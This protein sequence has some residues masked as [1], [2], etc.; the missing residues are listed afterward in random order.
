MRFLPSAPLQSLAF[1]GSGSLRGAVLMGAALALVGSAQAFQDRYVT[2]PGMPGSGLTGKQV[3]GVKLDLGFAVDLRSQI[4]L[5][6]PG[7]SG[8]LDGGLRGLDASLR[9]QFNRDLW[10]FALVEGTE[11]ELTLSQAAL[12]YQGLSGSS[13]LRLG[14]LPIDFGKQMQAR[15]YELPYPERP[16]VLRAYLGDQVLATGITYGDVFATGEHSTLR[17]SLGLF[18]QTERQSSPIGGRPLSLPGMEIL[19]GPRLDELAVNA[20]LTG[21]VDVGAEGIFQWGFSAHS[22]PD[23]SVAVVAS[24]GTSLGAEHLQHWI[25]GMDLT[26]GLS[27]ETEGPAWSAGWE[28]L[29][30]DGQVGARAVGAGPPTLALFEEQIFGQYYWLEHQRRSGR[31]LGL[32][33]STFEQAQAGTPQE[34]EISLYFSRPLGERSTLRF[35]VSHRDVEGEEPSERI[36]VQWIGLAGR[37]GHALDW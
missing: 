26:F 34:Q 9:A 7:R 35:Q 11:Q 17:A 4:S 13:Y 27:D 21:L 1:P 30:A 16:G 3:G 25:Y 29:I 2:S 5:D 10:G 33:Y 22:V 8:E 15:P 14:R 6:G 23:F 36:L 24:D 20:R 37:L 19:D 12:V 18:T 28:G 32:L 31:A